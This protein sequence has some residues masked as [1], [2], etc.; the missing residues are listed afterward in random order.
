MYTHHYPQAKE[1]F[2]PSSALLGALPAFIS[3]PVSVAESETRGTEPKP[4]KRIKPSPYGPLHAAEAALEAAV[5]EW[6]PRRQTVGS[7]KP[8]FL[9][10]YVAAVV[11][12]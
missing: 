9:S 3:T 8:V 6:M 4:T 7:R 5:Q 1:I 2:L 11:C 12:K 10:A